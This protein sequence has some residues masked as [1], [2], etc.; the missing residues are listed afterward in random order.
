MDFN[1]IAT[2]SGK[3]GLFHVIA[4]TKGGVILESMDEQKKKMVVS[5]NSKI[6][7]LGEIS[8]YTTDK[9]GTRTLHEV[10]M[11]IHQE[12]DG[13][14]G[15]TGTSDSE[16]LKSFLKFILP[17][18]DEDRVYVSDIKK[19]V[20]WYNLLSASY[21]ELFQEDKKEEEKKAPVKEEKAD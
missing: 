18:Y 11:K 12:F 21:S 1:E 15:L 17:E 3:G 10:M 14:T 9:E 20:N 8:I 4:P 5:M 7:V 2:V 6:S 19:L 16:E 13:D